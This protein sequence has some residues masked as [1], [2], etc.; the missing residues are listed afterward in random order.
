M[1]VASC[2]CSPGAAAWCCAV[3][4]ST[5]P[6]GRAHSQGLSPEIALHVH[7]FVGR[8]V[9][10]VGL[11]QDPVLAPGARAWLA[12]AIA[13]T[14]S[15]KGFARH[16]APPHNVVYVELTSSAAQRNVIVL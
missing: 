9:L 3:P 13:T 1:F 2:S 5:G 10:L 11:A 16:A 12:R 15:F 14:D 6:C 4:C 7:H 8:L